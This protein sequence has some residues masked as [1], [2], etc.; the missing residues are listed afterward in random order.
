M[1]SKH[2]PHSEALDGSSSAVLL[3][4]AWRR[5][6][7]VDSACSACASLRPAGDI[8]RMPCVPVCQGRPSLPEGVQAVSLL[9]SLSARLGSS[10]ESARFRSGFHHSARGDLRTP[11]SL[12]EPLA[13]TGATAW[14]LAPVQGIGRRDP[15]GIRDVPETHSC[16]KADKP[17]KATSIVK[18]DPEVH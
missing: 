2:G 4:T 6:T 5:T 3:S 15:F 13:C 16:A 1:S 8:R 7:P 18:D 12:E 10:F 17:K 11:G 14:D 9:S